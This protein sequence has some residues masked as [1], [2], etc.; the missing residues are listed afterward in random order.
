MPGPSPKT[1]PSFPPDFT[2]RLSPLLLLRTLPR[3]SGLLRSL[4][5]ILCVPH[6]PAHLRPLQD[7]KVLLP[8]WQVKPNC[9]EH[10]SRV[11]QR[12][13]GDP[14]G[15]SQEREM[16]WESWESGA[17]SEGLTK[18]AV[19]PPDVLRLLSQAPGCSAP[20][21]GPSCTSGRQLS[22]R[23]GIQKLQA[24]GDQPYH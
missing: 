15:E 17:I 11:L 14:Q 22:E 9:P 10:P 6:L 21:P 19:P 7:T 5:P 23:A 8:S 24:E 20:C 12:V 18:E 16:K 13:Y 1:R 2:P 4:L 3:V